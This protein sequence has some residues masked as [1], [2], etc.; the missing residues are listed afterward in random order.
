MRKG[1]EL[2]VRTQY[3]VEGENTMYFRLCPY[4]PQVKE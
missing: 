4:N 2:F 1:I 3:H